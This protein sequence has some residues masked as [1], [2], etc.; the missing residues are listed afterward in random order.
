VSVQ[1]RLC[2]CRHQI[3]C[4]GTHGPFASGTQFFSPYSIKLSNEGLTSR[5]ALRPTIAAS[6]AGAVVPA[7]VKAAEVAAQEAMAAT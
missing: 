3:G 1:V 5:G 6:R 4:I 2:R 7:C